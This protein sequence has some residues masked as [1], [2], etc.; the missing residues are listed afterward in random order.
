MGNGQTFVNEQYKAEWLQ[1][2]PGTKRLYRDGSYF[3]R[4]NGVFVV[5]DGADNAMGTVDK[6]GNIEYNGAKDEYKESFLMAAKEDIE[7]NL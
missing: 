3:P 4:E 5:Y 6:A 2:V 7:N 1:V